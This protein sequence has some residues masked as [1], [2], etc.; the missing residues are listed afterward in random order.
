MLSK[1]KSLASLEDVEAV[2]KDIFNLMHFLA[3]VTMILALATLM[4]VLMVV[5]TCLSVLECEIIT[6][7]A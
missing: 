2:R 4:S 5:S 7:E 1:K 3:S 6:S